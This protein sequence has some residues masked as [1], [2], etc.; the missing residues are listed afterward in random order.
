[1]NKQH[2][3][4]PQGRPSGPTLKFIWKHRRGRPLAMGSGYIRLPSGMIIRRDT[5]Q[6]WMLEAKR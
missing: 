1:M 4:T 6:R 2:Y 5:L 3:G